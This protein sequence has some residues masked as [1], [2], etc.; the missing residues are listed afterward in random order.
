[1]LL[2]SSKHNLCYPNQVSLTFCYRIYLGSGLRCQ[3][4][5]KFETKNPENWVF[6]IVNKNWP[7]NTD[8]YHLRAIEKLLWHEPVANMGGSS[9]NKQIKFFGRPMRKRALVNKLILGSCE[10]RKT[11]KS[12]VNVPTYSHLGYY[13]SEYNLFVSLEL[14]WI[15]L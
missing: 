10:E 3:N 12:K 13:K 5:V 14:L 7:W 4:E 2:Y 11:D 8:K 15:A 9:L 1:M 6:S